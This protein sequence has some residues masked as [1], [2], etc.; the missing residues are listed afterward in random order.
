[1]VAV[2]RVELTAKP[3]QL[4]LVAQEAVVTEALGLLVIL[5]TEQ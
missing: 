3:H 2:V 4:D 1:V 5:K